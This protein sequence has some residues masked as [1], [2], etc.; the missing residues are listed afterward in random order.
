MRRA[1]EHFGKERLA[2]VNIFCL[3]LAVAFKIAS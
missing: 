2:Y 1:F 3:Q